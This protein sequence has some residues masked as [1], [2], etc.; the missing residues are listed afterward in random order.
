MGYIRPTNY[1]LVKEAEVIVLANA[2]T[3]EKKGA[4]H[5]GKS[6]GV[7]RFKVS[8]SIKGD[9]KEDF[10]SVEGDNNIRSWGDPDDFSFTKGD[11]GPCNPTDYELKANY[12]L[13]LHKWKD[14]WFVGGPPFTRV[15]VLVEGPQ[16]PWTRAVRHYARIAQLN[17]YDKEKAALHELRS[18]ALANEADCPKGLAKDI[19]AHFK[20]PTPAKSFSDLKVLYE[21]TNDSQTREYVL[22]A[23]SHGK[24]DE[25]KEF[26]RA[27]LANGQWLTYT[28]PV[29]SYVAKLKLTGFHDVFAAAL[30]TNRL[31]N[32]R[33]M[34]LIALSGSAEESETPLMQRVLEST[35]KDEAL[36]LADWFVKHPSKES[37]TRFAE[38]ARKDYIENF[39]H[40]IAL[41]GMGDTNVV[42]WA[43][44][45]VK[46][47]SKEEWLGYY[48]FA[49]SPLPGADVLARQVIQ[50]GDSAPLVSLVQGYQDSRRAD[51][52]D[53]IKD[54]ALLKK[55]SRKLIYW[56]RRTLGD[57]ANAGDKQA[58]TLLNQLPMVDS[59]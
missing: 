38:W 37:I 30:R 12:V 18:R 34:L 32:E 20:K 28:Y 49:Q 33:R 40:T 57:W 11:H 52:L 17:D 21:R 15:N 3:F 24:K 25:A 42:D 36:I 35:D 48:V 26:F 41:A 9:C 19:D 45:F 5:G 29:C 43:R 16:A 6:F 58:E 13:F 14:A 2:L 47:S 55:K 10:I 53:R 50:R 7:F 54:I 31:E 8:E 56:L 39:Q 46:R 23:C 44:E 59:E 4:T 1:E 27:L 22:W 51:R